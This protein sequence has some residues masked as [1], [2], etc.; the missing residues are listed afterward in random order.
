[1][2]WTSSSSYREAIVIT[3]NTSAHANENV[4]RPSKT[5]ARRSCVCGM[6]LTRESS[7]TSSTRLPRRL[8]WHQRRLGSCA[9]VRVSRY[10]KPVGLLIALAALAAA[11]TASLQA[12]RLAPT[13]FERELLRLQRETSPSANSY[14]LARVGDIA[15]AR[16]QERTLG[17]AVAI[18]T[19]FGVMCGDLPACRCG[20]RSMGLVAISSKLGMK[21]IPQAE[22]K[23]GPGAPISRLQFAAIATMSDWDDPRYARLEPLR[24]QMAERRLPHR[25][26]RGVDQAIKRS[27]P[28]KQCLY[29]G[30]I[31]EIRQRNLQ[32]RRQESSTPRPLDSAVSTP[33]QHLNLESLQLWRRQGRFLRYRRKPER[34]C[35]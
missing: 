10:P 32:P 27:H 18:C 24:N 3:P 31:G 28:F 34:P 5:T 26:S 14:T 29:S 9:H 1:M 23:L 21:P 22:T 17:E 13:K 30:L 15:Q 20:T 25:V 16:Q 6:T 12:Q 19:G 7:P 35:L 2:R 11:A 33:R 8:G 4:P